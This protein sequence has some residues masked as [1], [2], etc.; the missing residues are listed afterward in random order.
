M[1]Y[2]AATARRHHGR[3]GQKVSQGHDLVQV[4]GGMETAWSFGAG[5]CRS[6]FEHRLRGIPGIGAEGRHADVRGDQ[7]DLL[8]DQPGGFRR[9]GSD[10]E[11]DDGRVG[12]V[13][14]AG[15]PC[16]G[17]GAFFLACFRYTLLRYV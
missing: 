16:W 14:G 11:V 4:V 5:G 13:V 7:R 1:C 8:Q 9:R 10:D 6:S 15:A 3:Q 2:Y 17:A 12:H